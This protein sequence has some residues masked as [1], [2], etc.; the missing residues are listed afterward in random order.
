MVRVKNLIFF[1]LVFL[2]YDALYGA[3]AAHVVMEWPIDKIMPY[4]VQSPML[5]HIQQNRDDINREIFTIYNDLNDRQSL[6]FKEK[7]VLVHRMK[8]AFLDDPSRAG[9]IVIVSQ[10]LAHMTEF[11]DVH[12][13]SKNLK[14]DFYSFLCANMERSLDQALQNGLNSALIRMDAQ[15][16]QHT[17]PR[18]LPATRP[19]LLAILD[20]GINV[21]GEDFKKSY[22]FL[23]PILRDFLTRNADAPVLKYLQIKKEL[24]P[25]VRHITL[26]D[27]KQKYANVNIPSLDI[28]SG[29]ADRLLIE[30]KKISPIN[31][32]V[33]P[34]I[35]KKQYELIENSRRQA[36]KYQPKDNAEW[37]NILKVRRYVFALMKP[38]VDE[39]QF[40]AMILVQKNQKA[41]QQR[42]IAQDRTT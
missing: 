14:I 19:N 42:S 7:E 21:F 24:Y 3:R 8:Q 33:T 27:L 2:S 28:W 37:E 13:G 11:F 35:L 41:A 36:D 5:G 25:Q 31:Y 38:T 20:G 26:K 4:S 16:L 17:F 40:K 18:Q 29:E 12:E 9:N 22:P 34:E 15:K 30:L 1:A 23:V 32:T 39:L 10:Y 6:L